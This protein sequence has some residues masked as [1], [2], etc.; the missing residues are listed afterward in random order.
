MKFVKSDRN[1]ILGGRGGP[2]EFRRQ[3]FGGQRKRSW[4]WP[5][6][7]EERQRLRPAEARSTPE[8]RSQGLHWRALD[9]FTYHTSPTDIAKLDRTPRLRFSSLHL[10]RASRLRQQRESCK[11][12]HE[13]RSRFWLTATVLVQYSAPLYCSALLNTNP[14][15]III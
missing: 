8:L 4:S 2:R 14:N 6:S 15:H 9:M 13:L 10:G 7:K 1:L 3:I 5:A 12:S 11:C